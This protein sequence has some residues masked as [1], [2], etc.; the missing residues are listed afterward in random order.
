M[1]VNKHMHMRM[2][3]SKFWFTE[4]REHILR[5]WSRCNFEGRNFAWTGAAVRNVKI[6]KWCLKLIIT[7]VEFLFSE[8]LSDSIRRAVR[9]KNCC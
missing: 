2:K 1:K 5:V 7:R 3:P 9:W 8:G 6:K 4:F